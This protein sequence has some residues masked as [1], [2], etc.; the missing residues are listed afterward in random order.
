MFQ[1]LVTVQAQFKIDQSLLKNV[2]ENRYLE[3]KSLATN[4]CNV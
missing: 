1:A 4:I 3:L 2:C